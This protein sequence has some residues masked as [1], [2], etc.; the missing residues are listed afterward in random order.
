M[1]KKSSCLL[2]LLILLFTVTSCDS[3][4]SGSVDF[5]EYE[6]SS[7]YYETTTLSYDPTLILDIDDS[8]QSSY[9]LAYT[10]YDTTNGYSEIAEGKCGNYYQSLDYE[11][12]IITF[13]SQEDGYIMEYVLSIDSKTGTAAIITDSTMDELYS[14][15]ALMSTCDPYL[16]VYTNVTRISEDFVADRSAV[17][18]KQV[19]TE[20]G[21]DTKIAY[22]WIDDQYSFA[23]KCEL[24][25][26]QSQELLLRWELTEFTLNVT[27]ES[28]KVDID[29]YTLTTD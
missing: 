12:N 17:R 5:G 7:E 2:L 26:A 13:L 16:P 25:D 27:E 9:A 21:V 29:D 20:D 22:I 3:D 14:G 18:Y 23:S 28:V 24:Y 10:F 4:N 8:W 19:Q 6:I 1:T 11:S 15:F